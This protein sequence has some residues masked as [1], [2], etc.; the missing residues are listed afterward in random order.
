MEIMVES[1]KTKPQTKKQLFFF[2][3]LPVLPAPSV[4]RVER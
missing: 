3:F 1:F 2:V 4:F